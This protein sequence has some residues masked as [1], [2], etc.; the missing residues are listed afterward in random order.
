MQRILDDIKSHKK[1]S[2]EDSFLL[3]QR[4]SCLLLDEQ[5]RPEGVN[6]LIYVADNWDN[7]PKDTK[8]V[9][10]EL[11]E[12]AGFYPYIKQLKIEIPSFGNDVRT[13]AHKSK[14][15]QKYFHIGQKQLSELIFSGKNI[16]ASAPTSFGKSL[17][18]E[19]IVA[20]QKFHNIVI[21]QP[22]LA[23]LDETRIKLSKY[24][25]DYRIIVRT[26]QKA[27]EQKKNIFL[28]TAERV[29]EYDSLPQID[30]LILDEFYK[31]SN[32]RGDNRSGVLNNAF[33]K[34]M[35][36]KQCQF[37]MLGPNIDSVSHEFLAKYNAEFYH[38]DYSLVVTEE[39]E[40]YNE[41]TIKRHGGKVNSDDVFKILDNID[42]QTLIF[43][44]SPS[45]SRNLA[46]SYS[47]HLAESGMSQNSSLPLIEWIKSNI[48]WGWSLTK[49]LQNGIGVHDGS[50][51]KHITSSTIRYFNENKLRFLFCTNTIIEGVNTSAK[52]VIFYDD[53]IGKRPVDYFDYSNIKGRAG[54]LMEHY[55]GKVVNLKKPPQKESIAIEIPIAD[56]N[57]IEK[58]ILV[59]LNENEIK[60][61]RDNKARYEEFKKLDS[62][63]Q[64]ILKRNGVSID[65][66]LKILN[67]IEQDIQ[68]YNS[69]RS[70]IYW[71]T[72]DSNLHK[73]IKYI[74]DL[75]WDNL[76]VG[77]ELKS[78]M[79]SNWVE[80]RI[81]SCCYRNSIGRIIENDVEYYL[82][83]LAQKNNFSYSNI[84][85]VHDAFPEEAQ[86]Q[87]DKVIERAFAFQKNWQAYRA[88]KWINVVDSLQKYACKKKGLQ[89]GDYSY[90]A[91]MLE[92]S[93]IPPEYRI[94]LEYGLP[95]SAVE[96]IRL[97]IVLNGI[98]IPNLDDDGILEYIRNNMR[99]FEKCLDEYEMSILKRI[100]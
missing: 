45:A 76:S 100:V 23:L 67:R 31:L 34:V 33:L 60:P 68:T 73:H 59:N 99:S 86:M 95:Q 88:P 47:K 83:Q 74:L 78:E 26:T 66:Q 41:V 25:D 35:R 7:M 13:E 98:Q 17:L 37:Y 19:E 21:I 15:I 27:S 61:I 42:G 62:E 82:K 52:N 24:R 69:Y 56:Q 32:N 75:C 30:F 28:L 29:L 58:E 57:P 77:D 10:A 89:P 8:I 1:I 71:S 91:E 9:W 63:L 97:L 16:V 5:S 12:S 93:F 38:T 40:K 92:N 36:N 72:V 64:T 84:R 49:C 46:F 14:Y 94:L 11:F 43:C 81:V 2:V 70:L 90:V 85:E 39:V 53:H 44:A 55:V 51:P 65:G 54:R 6:N 3:A 79:T 22:T 87:I 50:M 20:S 96:K 18:I 80:N 4:I 48:S